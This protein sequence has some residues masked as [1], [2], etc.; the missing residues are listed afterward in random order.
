MGGARWLQVQFLVSFF[1]ETLRGGAVPQHQSE[2]MGRESFHEQRL[3]KVVR[4]DLGAKEN[5]IPRDKQPVA[6]SN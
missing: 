5:V 1:P 3:K 6:Q 2:L 4:L